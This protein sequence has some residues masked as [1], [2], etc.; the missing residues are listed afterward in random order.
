M[1]AAGCDK[2]CI[3]YFIAPDGQREVAWIALAGPHEICAVKAAVQEHLLGLGA[4]QV[5]VEPSESNE[6]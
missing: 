2:H 3:I 5:R 1:I 4:R 6:S